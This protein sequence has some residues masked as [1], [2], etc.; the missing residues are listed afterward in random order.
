MGQKTDKEKKVELV[1]EGEKQQ[2]RPGSAF[3]R[4]FQPIRN[5]NINP[6]WRSRVE[7]EHSVNKQPQQ[8]YG[9]VPVKDPT[10]GLNTKA[11]LYGTTIRPSPQKQ[12]RSPP[13][14]FLHSIYAPPN[15]VRQKCN[16]GN[17]PLRGL[18]MHQQDVGVAEASFQNNHIGSRPGSDLGMY[19]MMPSRCQS[20]TTLPRPEPEIIDEI[21]YNNKNQQIYGGHEEIHSQFRAPIRSVSRSINSKNPSINFS[22]SHFPYANGGFVNPTNIENNFDINWS[23][24]HETETIPWSTISLTSWLTIVFGSAIFCLGGVRLYWRA[25][26]AKGQELFY[27]ISAICNGLVGFFA[28]H[29]K[30]FSMFVATFLLCALNVVFIFVPFLSGILPL[31]PLLS[32]NNKSHISLTSTKEPVEVDIGLAVLALMQLATAFSLLLYGCKA[33]GAT[34]KRVEQLKI[35]AMAFNLKQNNENQQKEN[36]FNNSANCGRI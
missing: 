36:L 22:P 31:V 5:Q 17:T 20:Y 27:G 35:L 11:S 6:I 19:K 14:N 10:P 26:F 30:S 15:M 16:N 1:E 24:D 21:V 4:E 25:D 23:S 28:S 18:Q 34:M 29:N 7:H 2:K 32:T 13:D 33:F 12:I 8:I 9:F 3:S